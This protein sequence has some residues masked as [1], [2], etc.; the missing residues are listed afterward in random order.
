VLI[1][2]A[3]FLCNNAYAANIGAIFE[4]NSLIGHSILL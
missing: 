3:D 1:P 2:P 4:R